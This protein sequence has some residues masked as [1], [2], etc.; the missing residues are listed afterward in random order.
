M[1]S[2]F[3]SMISVLTANGNMWNDRAFV[4]NFGLQSYFFLLKMDVLIINACITCL[5]C[6]NIYACVNYPLY[7]SQSSTYYSDEF[8]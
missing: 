6:I 1:Q 8:S 3:A 4:V 7:L 5:K 2:H